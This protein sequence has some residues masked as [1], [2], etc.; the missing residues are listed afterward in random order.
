[1]RVDRQS[2]ALGWS[3]K[4]PLRKWTIWV[5]GRRKGEVMAKDK[6]SAE[7]AA[8]TKWRIERTAPVEALPKFPLAGELPE[9]DE[10]A[11][12][13]PSGPHDAHVATVALAILRWT[14]ATL[15]SRVSNVRHSDLDNL[16]QGRSTGTVKARV[17]RVL[18][19][20]GCDLEAISELILRA[21]EAGKEAGIGGS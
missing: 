8:R 2:G 7:S 16:L 9:E 5:G 3:E 6:L 14:R 13:E 15:R 4:R 18:T 17:F 21:K 11:S 10:G 20:A 12:P 19:E 1:V